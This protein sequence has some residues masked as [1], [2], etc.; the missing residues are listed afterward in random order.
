M[1]NIK[2]YFYINYIYI[3]E[4]N[5]ISLIINIFFLN[6][7]KTDFIIYFIHK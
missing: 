7:I 5:I 4:T 1:H 3:K 2:N 6:S